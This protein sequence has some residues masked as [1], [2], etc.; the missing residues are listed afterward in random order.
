M[1][2]KTKNQDVKENVAQH[3]VVSKALGVTVAFLSLRH[4]LPHLGTTNIVDE[5]M[6][7]DENRVL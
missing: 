2:L 4:I 7:G 1:V 6:T 3:L 5:V